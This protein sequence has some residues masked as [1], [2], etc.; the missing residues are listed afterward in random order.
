LIALSSA[1]KSLSL[2]SPS[3][4]S[5]FLGSKWIPHFDSSRRRYPGRN[6]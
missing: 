2:M 3:W 6:F 5:S 1:W 4:A